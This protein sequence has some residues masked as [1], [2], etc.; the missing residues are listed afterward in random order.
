[1]GITIKQEGI[2]K[3]ASTQ[4]IKTMTQEHRGS[5]H[6]IS[7]P[8]PWMSTP[9]PPHSP[10]SQPPFR[11]YFL[12]GGGGWGGCC[13]FTFNLW[14][15]FEG[16]RLFFFFS[17]GWT[18]LIYGGG[19]VVIIGSGLKYSTTNFFFLQNKLRKGNFCPKLLGF[20]SESCNSLRYAIL[21]EVL[22]FYK[23]WH[24]EVWNA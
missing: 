11:W 6:L 2:Y 12:T 8:P 5:S 16:Y 13:I 18:Y 4:D 15:I 21:Q 14:K 22:I 24:G 23:R 9:P 10:G 20:P 17:D 19:G 1:M 3:P 7:T